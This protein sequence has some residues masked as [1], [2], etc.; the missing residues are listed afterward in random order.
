[1]QA[2]E[3]MAFFVCIIAIIVYVA[4]KISSVQDKKWTRNGVIEARSRDL[5]SALIKASKGE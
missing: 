1:M 2:I 3:L 4:W 5:Q